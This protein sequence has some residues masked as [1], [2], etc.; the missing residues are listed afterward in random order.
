MESRVVTQARASTAGATRAKPAASSAEATKIL[1]SWS[2]GREGDVRDHPSP[3]VRPAR[4]A[5]EFAIAADEPAF[6]KLARCAGKVRRAIRIRRRHPAE[7]HDPAVGENDVEAL[8]D[9]RDPNGPVGRAAVG[10]GGQGGRERRRDERGR[11]GERRRARR[12]GQEGCTARNSMITLLPA[13][14]AFVQTAPRV[15][16]SR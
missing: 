1:R 6:Q 4:Q 10:A 11:Q 12:K 16:M 7:A 2:P 15:G 9:V 3:P 13:C 8:V 5:F 14:G